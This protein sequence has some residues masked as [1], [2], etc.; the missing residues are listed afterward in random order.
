[1]GKL[2]KNI[3]VHSFEANGY[4]FSILKKNLKINNIES[5]SYNVA[6]TD[7]T[8]K[9]YYFPKSNLD[10]FKTLGSYSLREEKRRES[11]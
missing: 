6:V 3:T 11:K 9:K 7:D 2:K 1:M 4:V 10:N 5:K 8:N